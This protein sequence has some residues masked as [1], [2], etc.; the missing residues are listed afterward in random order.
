M[1]L[2]SIDMEAVEKRKKGRGGEGTLKDVMLIMR[3]QRGR[4]S[5]CLCLNPLSASYQ[6]ILCQ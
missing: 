4:E 2:S 6:F 5:A 3:A 1:H